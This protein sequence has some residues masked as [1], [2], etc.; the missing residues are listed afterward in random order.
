MFCRNCGAEALDRAVVCTKCGVLMN[1]GNNYCPNCGFQHDPK[2]VICI[3]CGY[4]LKSF[5]PNHH[6]DK[7]HTTQ[8]NYSSIKN[9][10]IHTLPEAIKSCWS[11]YAIFSG[12]ACRAEYWFWT[13]FVSLIG[14]FFVLVYLIAMGEFI[15]YRYDEGFV[16]AVTII[17]SFVNLI[18]FLPSLSVAVRRLHDIGLSGWYYL[19]CLVPVL[20]GLL[21][22]IWLTNDSVENN[23]YGTNPKY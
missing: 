5:I 6:R 23:Q 2:A 8:T 4:E 3:K 10:N 11:K 7:S 19:I 22:L 18:L 16:V 21:L 20:G 14:C 13:L 9:M 15:T 12:R 1:D 17:S